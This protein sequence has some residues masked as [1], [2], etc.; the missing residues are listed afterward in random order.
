MPVLYEAPGRQRSLTV[1]ETATTR[2]LLLVG[3]EEGAMDLHSEETDS[4]YLWFHKCSALA[5]QPLRRALVLG[6]GTFTAPKCLALDY[7]EAQFDVVDS[8]PGLEAIGRKFFRLDRPEFA[9]I[10]FHGSR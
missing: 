10:A 6:A 5:E 1:T 8:E 4:D 3:C 9:R 7:P 2:F